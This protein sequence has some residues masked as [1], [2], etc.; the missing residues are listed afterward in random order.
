MQPFRSFDE[1]YSLYMESHQKLWNR[2]IHLLGW[3]IA[4]GIVVWAL[5]T[6]H[7]AILG[8]APAVGL[9][10]IWLGHRWVEPTDEIEFKHP[11]LTARANLRMF[12][13]MLS[14]KLP[15]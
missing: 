1:F 2:R 8:L 13:H 6:R 7:F 10:A 14:G 4:A 9:L 11:I 15:F 12:A 3:S 5:I